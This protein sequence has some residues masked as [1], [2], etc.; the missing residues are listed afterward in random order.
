MT[1]SVFGATK[2]DSPAVELLD[3]LVESRPD[4]VA[5]LPEA[6]VM[7]LVVNPARFADPEASIEAT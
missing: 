2:I 3:V 7:S 6:M 1:R 5:S 4:E